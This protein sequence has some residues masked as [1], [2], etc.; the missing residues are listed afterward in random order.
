MP[1]IGMRNRPIVGFVLAT[2]LILSA[3][4]SSPGDSPSLPSA[5]S[6]TLS[7]DMSSVNPCD[8][9]ADENVSA[10]IPV[11]IRAGE[12]HLS[13]LPGFRDCVFFG[14]ASGLVTVGIRQEPTAAAAA[15]ALVRELFPLDN[16]AARVTVGRLPAHYLRCSQVWSPCREAIAFVSEPYF[17]VISIRSAVS[18]EGVAIAIASAVLANLNQ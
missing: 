12:E 11:G 13:A 1:V 8:Y 14:G 4:G 9:I 15:E 7:V 3:C 17:F 10:V 6:A 5:A 18:D 2:M 16:D